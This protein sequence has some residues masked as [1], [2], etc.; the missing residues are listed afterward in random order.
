M[1]DNGPSDDELIKH[2]VQAEINKKT[3][4]QQDMENRI[5]L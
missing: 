4:E 5:I 2:V 1:E 3:E